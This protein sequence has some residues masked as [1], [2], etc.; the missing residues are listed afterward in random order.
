MKYI[1][2]YKTV[3]LE[4]ATKDTISEEDIT[5]IKEVLSLKYSEAEKIQCEL[6]NIINMKAIANTLGIELS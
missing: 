2:K 6:E 5:F 1:D 3:I 4:I